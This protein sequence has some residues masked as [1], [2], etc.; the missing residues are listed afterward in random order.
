MILLNYKSLCELACLKETLKEL[1]A[2]RFFKYL[3]A[4]LSLPKPRQEQPPAP[5][6]PSLPRCRTERPSL[7]ERGLGDT[8]G[9]R[10]RRSHLPGTTARAVVALPELPHSHS[11]AAEQRLVN[12]LPC[13]N[14]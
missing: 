13:F 6:A 9:G 4:L 7:L 5:P 8:R 12:D 10:G 14:A 11:I 2:R 1:L 3:E